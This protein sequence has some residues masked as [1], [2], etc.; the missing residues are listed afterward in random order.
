MLGNLGSNDRHS[1]LSLTTP[2]T[3]GIGKERILTGKWTSCWLGCNVLHATVA[4]C[5]G[6][7][8]AARGLRLQPFHRPCLV[9]LCRCTLSRGLR[10]PRCSC[11]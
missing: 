6:L 10:P 5:E 11:A 3:Y 8:H 2:Q 1:S 7:R 9:P 4:C